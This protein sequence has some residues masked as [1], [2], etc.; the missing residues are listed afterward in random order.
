MDKPKVI[1]RKPRTNKLIIML[2]DHPKYKYECYDS[3][4]LFL[5]YL[6]EKNFVKPLIQ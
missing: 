5:S 4:G 1:V 3:N 2:S 6:G